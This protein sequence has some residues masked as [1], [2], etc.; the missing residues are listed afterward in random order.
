MS[1]AKYR[2]TVPLQVRFNDLDVL[3][4]VTNAVYQVYY[5]QAGVSYYES[6][7]NE[8]R[9]TSNINFVMATI[10]IDYFKSIMF[11]ANIAV[12]IRVAEIGEKSFEFRGQII[13]LDDGTLYSRS[14]SQEVCYNS[15]Q[16]RTVLMPEIWRT[17]IMNYEYTAPL[18]RV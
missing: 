6:V 11:N 2:H 10:T 13:D 15:Q 17:N 14:I 16:R 1:D 4:H 12:Q 18:I 5:S 8:Q 3:G 7:L 9:Y